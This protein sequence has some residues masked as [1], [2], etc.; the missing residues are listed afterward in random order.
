MQCISGAEALPELFSM[1]HAW[2]LYM[3]WRFC[4]VGFIG[5]SA[6]F[7]DTSL[8]TTGCIQA[9]LS[10]PLKGCVSSIHWDCRASR[11]S[12]TIIHVVLSSKTDRH[13]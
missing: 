8:N 13:H 11:G 9:V 10:Q 12:V 2:Q 7:T 5:L 1:L 3:L 6:V 4:V